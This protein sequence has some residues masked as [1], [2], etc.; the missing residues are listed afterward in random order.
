MNEN[1][2]KCSAE[3]ARIRKELD[4]VLQRGGTRNE[5]ALL[6][7]LEREASDRLLSSHLSEG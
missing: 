7:Y 1:Q 2:V 5:I 4:E 3:L 6:V